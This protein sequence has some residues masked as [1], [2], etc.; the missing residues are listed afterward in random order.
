[1]RDAP[2]SVEIEVAL[3][4]LSLGLLVLTLAWSDWIEALF[5]IDPDHGDGSLEWAVVGLT[6]VSAVVFSGLAAH[7]W[8]LVRAP[9]PLSDA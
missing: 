6:A 4:L 2:R 3:A 7:R 1:M 9:R 5:R 8:R